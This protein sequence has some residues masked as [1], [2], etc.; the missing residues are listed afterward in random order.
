MKKLDELRTELLAAQMK[1]DTKRVGE[2]VAQISLTRAALVTKINTAPIST[3]PE[4]KERQ[5]IKM[6]KK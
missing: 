5:F 1:G 2:I 3:K 4:I 6:R